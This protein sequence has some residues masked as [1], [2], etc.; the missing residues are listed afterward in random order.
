MWPSMARTNSPDT[1]MKIW[2]TEITNE[3]TKQMKEEYERQGLELLIVMEYKSGEPTQ[4]G[5]PITGG[6][7]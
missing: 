7:L 4:M 3:F 6:R 5:Q 1:T 2:E